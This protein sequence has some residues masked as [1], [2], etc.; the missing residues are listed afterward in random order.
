MT[1]P[2]KQTV[3]NLSSRLIWTVAAACLLAASATAQSRPLAIADDGTFRGVSTPTMN[4]FLGIRYAQAPVGDLRWRPPRRPQ[5]VR[6]IQDASQF[7]NHCPQP[8]SPF[9]L[10]SISEDC[11][12]LNVFTPARQDADDHDANRGHGRGLPVMFW[13]HGGALVVGESDDYNPE[14]LVEQGVVVVTINYRLGALGFLAHPA[15]SAEAADPDND[16]DV[17]HAP[18]SGNYGIM[19]QQLALRWV[20]RN[21]EAFGG[22]P[23]NVTIFGESAGGLSTFSNLVSPRARGLFER[24][25][26]ESGAYRLNL[27]SLATAEAQ[28]TAFATAEGCTDQ[29]AACLRALTVAQVLAKENPAGYVTNIDGRV[30]PQSIDTALA[31]GEFNRVPVINGSNHDE[32]RLFVALNDVFAGII[33]TPTNYPQVIAGT[34]GIPV[35]ATGPIV[36][37]YPPGTT[38]ESTELAL[39]AL[40]TD[41]I[42]ACP[43][44]FA[45]ALT[46]QFV[47]TFAYEFND[48]NAPEDFLPF[49]GFPYGAAHASE[50]QYLFG[51][52]P[53]VPTAP[54]SADQQQLAGNMVEYWTAFAANGN[55]N[56]LGTPNWPAFSVVGEEIQSLVPT[57]VNETTFAIDH[58]CAFWDAASGRTLP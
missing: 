48:E 22:D 41:A 15:L 58:K 12:F 40:G 21:I 45:S 14:H 27:P 44:H 4:E 52:R 36:A 56:H 34:L 18:A 54:L 1:F 51:V 47:P 2:G 39:G 13:M 25:I 8:A 38:T 33:P 55:P 24:A 7:A 23:H 17:D 46:S 43:A 3:Q 42:F 20:K 16:N 28:G 50:L 57:P 30:L 29:S 10:A 26:V 19:D 37:L 49:A 31:A 35:A 53:T 32:W 9:G 6:G 5:P 11:L